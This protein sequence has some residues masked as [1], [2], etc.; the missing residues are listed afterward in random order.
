MGQITAVSF[1]PKAKSG[2]LRH[3]LLTGETGD[4]RWRERRKLFGSEFHF[5][6]PSQLVMKTHAYVTWWLSSK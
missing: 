1:V 5:E 2:K 6:G 3:V 4:L